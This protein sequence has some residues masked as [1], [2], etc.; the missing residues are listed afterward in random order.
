MFSFVQGF[1]L[2][3]THKSLLNMNLAWFLLHEHQFIPELLWLYANV[4]QPDTVMAKF[5]ISCRG[6]FGFWGTGEH[7][8]ILTLENP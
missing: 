1:V 8:H 6:G 3:S 7:K 4:T 5:V 2:P